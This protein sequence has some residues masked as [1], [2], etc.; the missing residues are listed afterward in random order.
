LNYDAFGDAWTVSVATPNNY[1]YRGE[2]YY[3]ELGL[4]YL[5]ARWYIPVTGRFLSRDPADG[6]ISDPKSLHK[7][8]YVSGDPVNRIDPSGHADTVT[9]YYLC[10]IAPH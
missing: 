9:S 3:S 8:L 5:R 7:D 1:L 6:S 2:H 4:Y 10:R